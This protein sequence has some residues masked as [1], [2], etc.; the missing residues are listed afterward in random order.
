[1]D[2]IID[3]KSN[4]RLGML[5]DYSIVHVS[6]KVYVFGLHWGSHSV[7]PFYVAHF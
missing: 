5:S 2:T 3:T 6:R 4:N 7:A 1:M